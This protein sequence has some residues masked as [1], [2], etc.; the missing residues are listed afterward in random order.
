VYVQELGQ[1]SL[2]A[3]KKCVL[4][5]RSG[6]T[7]QRVEV[8]T[9]GSRVTGVIAD[10]TY[11]QGSD[12]AELDSSVAPEIKLYTYRDSL[13]KAASGSG[14]LLLVSSV[15]AILAAAIALILVLPS[16]SDTSAQQV[17]RVLMAMHSTDEQSPPRLIEYNESLATQCIDEIQGGAGVHSSE[18]GLSCKSAES[19]GT[20]KLFAF[21]GGIVA[22][23]VA[24]VAMIGAIRKAYG[25]QRNP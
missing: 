2:P 24:G 5:T 4:R 18:F 20:K 10:G 9:I 7:T 8:L 12:L 6:S 23:L 21:I 25:F 3:D 22:L 17:Q 13:R 14:L 19:F 15:A 11:L 1:P 16:W